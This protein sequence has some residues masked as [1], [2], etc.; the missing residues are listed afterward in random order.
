MDNIGSFFRVEKDEVI[1]ASGVYHYY[2]NGEL[3]TIVE[4]W[5]ISENGQNTIIR[6]VRNAKDYQTSISAVA[7]V[8]KD[9]FQVLR[10]T[11]VWDCTAEGQSVHKEY[12]FDK[13]SDEF[14]GQEFIFFPLLRIFMGPVL[15]YLGANGGQGDVLIP[16]IKDPSDHDQLLKPEIT[17]RRAISLAKGVE[18]VDGKSITVQ[19]YDYRGDQYENGSV[20]SVDEHC[21]LARYQW[22]QSETLKWDVRLVDYNR[23]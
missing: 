1:V 2:L 22:Q 13:A 16:Y 15:D 5:Q 21:V 4:P 18:E 19:K 14:R 9:N 11:T 20:F 3:T 6:S 17:Q 10:A 23:L 8:N 7:H 12:G